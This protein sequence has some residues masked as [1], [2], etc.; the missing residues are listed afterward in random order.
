MHF[1]SQVD[2]SVFSRFDSYCNY[3]LVPRPKLQPKYLTLLCYKKNKSQYKINLL[4]KKGGFGLHVNQ[5]ILFRV[6]VIKLSWSQV[7]CSTSAG[8]SLGVSI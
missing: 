8:N 1:R 4:E 2:L 7:K 5:L 3:G 6:Q